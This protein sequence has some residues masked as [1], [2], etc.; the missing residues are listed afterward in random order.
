R[1]AVR[2][3]HALAPGPLVD[4]ADHVVHAEGAEALREGVDRRA[5]VGEPFTHLSEIGAI[6]IADVRIARVAVRVGEARF[7]LAGELPLGLRAEARALLFAERLGL[8]PV[9]VRHRERLG[10]PHELVAIDAVALLHVLAF[11][12]R[13][14]LPLGAPR[15]RVSARR[16]VDPFQARLLQAR[17][18]LALHEDHLRS[19]RRVLV[20]LRRGAE[21]ESERLALLPP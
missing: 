17:T 21:E 2:R 20:G 19:A 15:V 10:R 7:A 11:A 5:V 16:W 18:V 8:G 4:V 12:R 9:H 1:G 3:A 13:G 6:E 14:L